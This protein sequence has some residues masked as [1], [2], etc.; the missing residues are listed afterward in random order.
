MDIDD[1]LAKRGLAPERK[2]RFAR[3]G[4]DVGR[5]GEVGDEERALQR[6]RKRLRRP[7][8]A[9]SGGPVER[10]G[11]AARVVESGL[12]NR[13]ERSHVPLGEPCLRDGDG[14]L[15][16]PR[17]GCN[18]RLDRVVAEQVPDDALGRDERVREKRRLDL[19]RV[20]DEPDEAVRDERSVG[21]DVDASRELVSGGGSE[22]GHHQ[23]D[24]RPPARYVVL[25]VRVEPLVAEVELGPER[26]NED[27]EVE[28]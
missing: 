18:A 28:G 8:L 12:R 9:A 22:Q 16:G 21:R 11:N 15:R 25:Q 7:P 14:G 4:R 23:V 1:A 24:A 19:L 20:G 5:P 13:D 2:N 27:S 6:V 10:E 3:V 26:D 17:E